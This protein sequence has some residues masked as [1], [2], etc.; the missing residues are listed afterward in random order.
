MYMYFVIISSKFSLRVWQF[1]IIGRRI[2]KPNTNHESLNLYTTD[3]RPYI[4]TWTLYW[5]WTIA[6]VIYSAGQYLEKMTIFL[7]KMLYRDTSWQTW[8]ISFIDNEFQ[9]MYKNKHEII[10][11]RISERIWQS[12]HWFSLKP[13]ENA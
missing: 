3:R 12:K 7:E 11:H 8:V 9:G 13:Y 6:S 4:V 1:K 10:L 2:E 5:H